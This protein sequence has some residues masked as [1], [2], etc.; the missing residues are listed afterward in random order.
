MTDVRQWLLEPD[1]PTIRYLSLIHLEGLAP[2][3]PLVREAKARIML[4]GTVPEILSR[5][6]GDGSWYEGDRFYTDKYKGSVWNLLL[7]AELYADKEDPSVKKACEYVLDQSQDRES[8]GFSIQYSPRFQGGLPSMVIPCLTGN[9]VYSLNRLGFGSDQRVKNAIEWIV[10]YQR[11]DDG[12]YRDEPDAKYLRLSEC[13]GRHSCHM[14]VVK[15]LKALAEIPEAMSS[16]E[17]KEKIQQLAEYLLSHHLYK[18][19][20][21][22]ESMAKPGWLRFG[23]PL[24]YQTDILEILEIFMQ[25]GIRD[26]RMEAALEIV[27][28]KAD[29]GTWILENSFNGK[30]TVAIETKGKPSKWITLKAMRILDHYR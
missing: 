25:L 7:L 28:N 13:F 15:S 6:A 8:H 29:S 21:D 10:K 3:N 9:M 23:F 14:G 19:S 11:A 5:Q 16:P 30:T 27:R 24:M 1:D 12:L 26:P 22:L 4:Q 20:H 17:I 2:D 18:K